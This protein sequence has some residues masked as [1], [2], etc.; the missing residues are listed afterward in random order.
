MISMHISFV[1]KQTFNF[2]SLIVRFMI[3]IIQFF[4][5]LY[6]PNV[7]AFFLFHPFLWYMIL[8]IIHT[9]AMQT[10]FAQSLLSF[11]ARFYCNVLLSKIINLH[12]IQHLTLIDLNV[13][14]TIK[15]KDKKNLLSVKFK[16]IVVISFY[17]FIKTIQQTHYFSRVT[18]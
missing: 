6:Q 2:K 4:I 12:F 13:V 5:R 11:P 15:S 7:K 9:F 17:L 14:Y 10:T 3:S 8:F 18:Y 16:L 1:I